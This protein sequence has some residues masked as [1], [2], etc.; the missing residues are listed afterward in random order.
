MTQRMSI[1]PELYHW[2][3]NRA[4]VDPIKLRNRF[5]KYD[6]WVSGQQCPTFRQLENFAKFTHV[7]FGALFMSKPLVEELPIQD[8]RTLKDSDTSK[9]SANLLDTLYMCG[10]RQ[11]WY[12]TFALSEGFEPLPF[13]GSTTIDS[14]IEDVADEIR[15][16]MDFGLGSRQELANW[17]QVLDYLSDQAD[18]IGILVMISSIVRNNLHR[19]L[20]PREFHGYTLADPMA[21]VIFINSADSKSSQIFIFLIGL[22]R[23]WLGESGLS[24]ASLDT[25]PLHPVAKW[26]YQVALEILVPAEFL[27]ENFQINTDLFDEVKRLSIQYKVSP[28][29]IFQQLYDHEVLSSQVYEE[30]FKSEL[31]RSNP[32]HGEHGP[33]FYSTLRSRVSPRFGEALVDSTLSGQTKFMDALYYLGINKISTLEAFGD[34]LFEDQN[35]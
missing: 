15:N 33:N 6:D 34:T 4:P 10:Q 32:K 12:H 14:N 19:K 17:T 21:P 27:L 23:L 3:C 9:P 29:V 16:L 8:L 25:T 1:K 35:Y 20:D 5:P 24:N 28:L 13:V 30:F 11:D 7:P 26:C 31:S 2:A 18:E 22:A